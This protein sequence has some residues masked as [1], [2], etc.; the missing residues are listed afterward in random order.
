MDSSV[1]PAVARIT[2]VETNAIALLVEAH[3]VL[4]AENSSVSMP[5][6][7]N[8]DLIQRPIVDEVTAPYGLMND[9]SNLVEFLTFSVALR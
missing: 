7:P 8:L 4:W 3:L 9:T 5:A 6:W 1:Q 2:S